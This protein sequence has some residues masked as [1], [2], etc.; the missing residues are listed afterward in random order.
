MNA[1]KPSRFLPIMLALAMTGPWTAVSALARID[2]AY[3][4]LDSEKDCRLIDEAKEDEGGDWAELLCTGYGDYPVYISYGDARD[5]VFFGYPPDGKPDSW[6]SFGGFNAAGKT[7][8]WRLED[9]A[10]FA[11]I[12]RW[13]VNTI[14]SGGENRS[15]EV[16]VVEKVA[17]P[18]S[19]ESCVV[20]Y[21][22][23]PGNP[24][25]NEQ[26]R[27]LA[28]EYARSFTCWRDEPLVME[29]S[30]PLPGPSRSK[31]EN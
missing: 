28:D 12:L 17:Q 22:V 1:I 20:G 2:S 6:E 24:G 15:I 23:A 16:L 21:V 18:D 8:E 10:P 19:H 4:S 5:S 27:A 26:A 7:V 25:H 13:S 30:V 3:T 31:R 29:G 11:T 9:G 14:T